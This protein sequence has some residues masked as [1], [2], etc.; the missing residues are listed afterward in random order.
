M[1]G[2]R[3]IATLVAEFLG[4]GILTLL[5][6]SVQR[7]TIGVPF[8]VAII[9]GL[10]FVVMIYAFGDLSGAYL[11]PAVTIALWTAR[12]VSS[13]RLI[14][15]VAAELLG[16]WAAS[17]VYGYFV[18]TKLTSIGGHFSG[19]TLA[20]ESVAAGVLGLAWGAAKFGHWSKAQKAGVIGVAVML[21]M[22]LA[23]S[24]G[25]GIANPALALGM[26]AWVWGTYALGPVIGAVVGVNLYGLLFAEDGA[27]SF[28]LMP[29]VQVASGSKSAPK[30]STK[31]PAAKK[32]STRK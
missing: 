7:S 25:I 30:K 19:R 17:F 14:L 24:G 16:A 29:K 3:K 1:L 2:K 26:R 6:L 20:A 21:A 13:L 5:V 28:N 22:V 23:S 31:K 11:N 27:L 8:F 15:L 12:K 18:N 4:T 10:V 32:R 9:A